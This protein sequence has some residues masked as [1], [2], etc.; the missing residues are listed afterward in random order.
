M[1]Q[2]SASPAKNK[3]SRQT[4]VLKKEN[5]NAPSAEKRFL[6]SPK[7]VHTCFAVCFFCLSY[8]FWA[9]FTE[10]RIYFRKDFANC[11]CYEC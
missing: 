9:F 11:M 3:I 1:F 7:Q 8:H 2:M 6:P 5:K 4:N 10:M